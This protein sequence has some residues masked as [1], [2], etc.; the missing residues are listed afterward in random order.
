MTKTR[1]QIATELVATT[2]RAYARKSSKHITVFVFTKSLMDT[3]KL[4]Q[5][6]GGSRYKHLDGYYWY[7]GK[8]KDLL[9]MWEE[10]Y[11]LL[12]LAG[13][14]KPP[15]LKPLYELALRFL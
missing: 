9:A 8:K 2:G 13:T 10:I 3:D 1:K 15:R 4:I 7:L 14:P 12:I 11:P 5:T 6:F